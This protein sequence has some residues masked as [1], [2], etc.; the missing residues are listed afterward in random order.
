MTAS[1]CKSEDLEEQPG[2]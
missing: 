1:V 2:G